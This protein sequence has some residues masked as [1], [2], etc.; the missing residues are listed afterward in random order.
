MPP[1]KHGAEKFLS[2]ED[3]NELEFC[4]QIRDYVIDINYDAEYY[5]ELFS[6]NLSAI[7]RRYGNYAME[8]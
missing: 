6:W 2:L 8:R 3:L 5:V 4:R 7:T 1:L